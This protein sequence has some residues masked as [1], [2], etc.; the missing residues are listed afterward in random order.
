MSSMIRKTAGRFSETS[1]DGEVVVMNLDSG[2][3]FSL[4]NTGKDI[5]ELIDGQRSRDAIL[6]ELAEA[7]GS[8]STA[9]A[10]DVDGFLAEL[11]EAGLVEPG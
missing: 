1:I 6:A 4:T 7:Y 10:A 5:W 11:R 3:F 2:D 9:I 8:E